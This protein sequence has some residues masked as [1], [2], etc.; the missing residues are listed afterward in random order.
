[1]IEFYVGNYCIDMTRSQIVDQDTIIS[2]EPK[3]LQVLLILAENQGRV[4]SHDVILNKVWPDSV[5]GANAIQRCIAQL[6]KAFD[7]DAKTQKVIS[8]HPKVGYSLLSDVRWQTETSNSNSLEKPVEQYKSPSLL[9]SVFIH[10]LWGVILTAILITIALFAYQKLTSTEQLTISN[11]T[12]LTTTDNK[13]LR[14]SY[15]PDGRY[16]A[17]E[18]YLGSCRN[19]LWA[20]DTQSNKEYLLTEEVGVYGTPI[21]SPDGSQIIFSS[22]TKCN[23]HNVLEGCQELRAL[24]FGLAKSSPQA[25]R[26]V[27][28]CN[29]KDFHSPVWLNNERIAFI[30][31]E[32]DHDKLLTMS[33]KD[34]EITTLYSSQPKSLH[35]LDY[36]DYLNLLALSQSDALS[37]FSLLLVEPTTAETT[38]TRL[39]SEEKHNNGWYFSWHPHQESLITSTGKSL[40]SL[41][42]E[43]KLTKFKFPIMEDIYTPRYHPQ[44]TSIVAAIGAFDSDIGQ[45]SWDAV[46]NANT[47][48]NTVTNHQMFARST[49]NEH[50]AK[51]QPQGEKIAFIS[52]RESINQVWLSN[53]NKSSSPP[54]QLSYFPD[55]E[56]VSALVWSHDGSLIIVNSGKGLTLLDLNGEYTPI[57]LDYDVVDI[58]HTIGESQLLLK[59]IE[60]NKYAIKLFNFDSRHSETLYVGPSKRALLTEHGKLFVID[61]KSILKQLMGDSLLPVANFQESKSLSI[62]QGENNHIL[63][64]DSFGKLWQFNVDSS[65]K[66]LFLKSQEDIGTVSD[67]LLNRKTL[68]F[69]K[70]I[71]IKKEIVVLN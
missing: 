42:L 40:Y 64:G 69:S 36:S 56:E 27:L 52:N 44:G 57:K 16:I 61:D 39:E 66:S 31:S 55:D 33:L 48:I 58:Y 70:V 22:V 24:S 59:V 35:S 51:Y 18:R 26:E 54:S 62:F 28:S 13:E 68:L 34:K 50:G 49:V 5:V 12:S 65:I 19:Q 47:P 9:N 23:K 67:I 11:L 30:S 41:D 45:L 17:F 3:V 53:Y 46:E 10:K 25:T 20:K 43:G 8:T 37:N 1:M 2:M 60:N 7:D 15:S 6:R 32:D 21:W 38:I 29:S 63:V 4:V 14:P 71:S